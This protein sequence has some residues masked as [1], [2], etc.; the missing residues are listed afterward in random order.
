MLFVKVTIVD[1]LIG[2]VIAVGAGLAVSGF[3][4]IVTGLIVGQIVYMFN[5]VTLPVLQVIAYIIFVCLT[6]YFTDYNVYAM[7]VLT[8]LYVISSIVE[9]CLGLVKG[10]AIVRGLQYVYY[11]W[12]RYISVNYSIS[13]YRLFRVI[14]CVNNSV[15]YFDVYLDS[16][17]IESRW[18][19]IRSI[20]QLFGLG[21][22]LVPSIADTP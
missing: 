7:I 17:Y 13:S 16:V 12:S 10:A 15:G 18:L 3:A 5:R 6:L 19:S 22:D 8:T 21:Y 20:N 9:Y 11:Y 14:M 1:I 4:N 2:I